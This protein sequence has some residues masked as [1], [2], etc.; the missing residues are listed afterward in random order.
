MFV[1]FNVKIGQGGFVNMLTIIAIHR[2]WAVVAHAL[3]VEK[4]HYNHPL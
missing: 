1:N 3:D 2:P 4:F